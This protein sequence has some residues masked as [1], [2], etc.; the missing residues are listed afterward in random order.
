M[1]KSTL[2]SLVLVLVT[3]MWGLTFPLIRDA[4]AF[5]DPGSFVAIRMVLATLVLL[6]FVITHFRHAN[7]LL[8]IGCLVLAFLNTATYIFQTKGL[9]TI[10][11]SRSAFITGASVI[12]VPL[13]MPLFRLGKPDKLAFAS[14]VLCLIGLYVL[15]GADFQNLSIGDFWTFDCAISYA[16]FIIVMQIMSSRVKDYLLLCFF[17][18]CFS[19]PLALPFATMTASS[20]VLQPAVII[21]LIFC[22]VFATCLAI[23]LQGRYQQYI[24]AAKTALIFALEPV[25]ATI[26]A[27]FINAGSTITMSTIVGGLLI[28]VSIVL[29]DVWLSIADKNN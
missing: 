5:I 10:P 14:V 9:V 29:R 13:L 25:F 11:A 7:R 1:Q 27:Y 19:V 22:A 6:P 18:I 16:L 12:M 23:Y 17:Q 26:F 24:T 2:A 28:L 20:I 8:F 3:A 4:V 21:A 15:T